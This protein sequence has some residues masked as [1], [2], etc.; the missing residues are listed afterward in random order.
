[1]TLVGKEINCFLANSLY[2]LIPCDVP[3]HWYVK[4]YFSQH[5]TNQCAVVRYKHTALSRWLWYQK[6]TITN[7]YGYIRRQMNTFPLPEK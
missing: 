3:I 2:P 1:M 7:Q 5:N 6:Y 4:I